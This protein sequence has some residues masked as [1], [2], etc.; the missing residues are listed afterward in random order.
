MPPV[1]AE[2]V[3]PV[4][5]IDGWRGGWV[6]AES[7]PG[8]VTMWAS[9]DLDE[10]VERVKGHDAIAIDMPIALAVSGRREAEAE[11]R[12]VLGSSARSVFTSPTRAALAAPTQAEATVVNRRN[13]GPGISAQ[14]FGLFASIRALRD[15]LGRIDHQRWHE[16]HPETAFAVMNAT[17][18]LPSKRTAVGVGLRLDLL[19]RHFTMVDELLTT[20]PERV[21][22]D[23]ALDALAALWSARR[24]AAGVADRFGPVGRDDEG[25]EHAVLV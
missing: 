20:A 10:V 1:P 2:V 24:I 11:L 17:R 8:G 15:A 7:G 5:G 6:V 9:G 19:R 3:A 21:P 4:A 13:G 25:F 16:T 22:I 23:D 18:P 12:G 14:A